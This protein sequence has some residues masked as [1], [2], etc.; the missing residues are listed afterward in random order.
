MKKENVRVQNWG[1]PKVDNNPD[2]LYD[3]TDNDMW[4]RKKL[5]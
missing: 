3:L 2:N 1:F 5:F 4:D